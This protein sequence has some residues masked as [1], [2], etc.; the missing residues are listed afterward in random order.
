MIEPLCEADF[1]PCAY[2]FRPPRSAHQ[3]HRLIKE[4][5][6]RGANWVVDGDSVRYFDTIDQQR[7][8]V[9]VRQRISDRRVRRLLRA[10]LSAGVLTA[11]GYEPSE[12]G[13][14]QGGVI[15][16]LRSNIYLHVLDQQ[17]QQ[18]FAHLGRLVR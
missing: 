7:L 11:D 2:G 15:S 5:V 16:P 9:L 10:W 13:T 3:A 17:W 1:L 12:Q 6:N 4:T 18:R 14:P 8:L